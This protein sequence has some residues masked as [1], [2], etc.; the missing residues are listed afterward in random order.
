MKPEPR[1]G[2][3]AAVISEQGVPPRFSVW[4]VGEP[5]DGE[6]QVLV[7]ASPIVAL[8]L[9][10]A[11]GTSYFGPP[12]LPYVP[13]VQGV[14]TVLSGSQFQPGSP[15]WF[16][17][18]AGM[19]GQSGS[20]AQVV[21]VRESDTVVLPPETDH[22]QVA[23]LG[24]SAVAAYMSLLRAGRL[25]S[26]EQV[27]ILGASGAVGQ[28]AIQVARALGAGRIIAASRS[29][30]G[31]ETALRLGAHATVDLLTDGVEELRHRIAS[32]VIGKLDLVIDPVCG[33]AAT[34]ALRVLGSHGRFVNLGSHGSEGASFDSA[35]LRSRSHQIVGYTNN[36]LSADQRRSALLAVLDLAARNLW[37][38][39]HEVVALEHIHEAWGGVADGSQRRRVVV[40][41]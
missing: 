35:I 40:T 8:D 20:L 38:V 32:A 13:G 39:E 26:G 36:D 14:G 6:C 7:S 28:V 29:A 2:S 3:H 15:V 24:L 22:I 4:P 25:Q 5:T 27:L 21:N 33:P 30:A 18:N 16:A 34:A 23:A 31:R 9:L 41:P 19:G 1:A 17:T 12:T 11:S 37:H 10:C